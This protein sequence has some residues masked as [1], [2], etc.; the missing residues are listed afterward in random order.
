MIICGINSFLSE[1][2]ERSCKSLLSLKCLSAT[3]RAKIF[4]PHAL[5]PLTQTRLSVCASLS[6]FGE[7]CVCDKQQLFAAT[8]RCVRAIEHAALINGRPKPSAAWVSHKW[9]FPIVQICSIVSL[10]ALGGAPCVLSHS[11]TRWQRA[12][13]KDESESVR[14]KP[15]LCVFN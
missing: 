1:L 2:N 7:G 14:A 5:L 3:W 8:Y 4:Q 12:S 11:L 6:R 15:S 13:E 9:S 10:S